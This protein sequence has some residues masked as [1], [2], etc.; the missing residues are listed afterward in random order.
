MARLKTGKFKARKVLP[1]NPRVGIKMD[2]LE[3]GRRNLEKLQK[4]A[5]PKIGRGSVTFWNP[6]PEQKTTSIV[7]STDADLVAQLHS[8]LSPDRQEKLL[9][10]IATLSGFHKILELAWSLDLAVQTL[11]RH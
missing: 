5:N 9:L 3:R 8:I 1:V 2:R 10:G 6:T 7:H 4:I 11:S